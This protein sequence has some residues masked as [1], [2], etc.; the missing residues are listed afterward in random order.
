MSK[1][2]NKQQPMSPE[3]YL[4]EKARQ[5]PIYKCYKGTEHG[6]IG[7]M[8]IVVARQHKQGTI[9]YAGFLLDTWCVGVKNAFWRFSETQEDFEELIDHMRDNLADFEEISYV[10]AHNWIYG[11]KDWATN[12]GIEPCKDFALAKYLLEE[13]DDNVELIEYDFG[14]EG[15][16]VLVAFSQQEANKY[17]PALDRNL[18]KGNYQVLIQV[19]DEDDYEP[20]KGID[21][22]QLRESLNKLSKQKDVPLMEYTYQ[23]AG[24]PNVIQLHHPEILSILYKKT[25]DIS[26][27]EMRKVLSL[28]SDRLREDLHNII[29]YEIG[30]YHDYVQAG[31]KNDTMLHWPLMGNAMMFLVNVGTKEESLPIVLEILRQD[32][33]FSDY[34]FSDIVSTFV[35]PL[36]WLYCKDE[37]TILMPYLLEKGL[38]TWMKAEALGM[39]QNIGIHC[40]EQRKIVCTMARDLFP[41]YK[42]DLPKR[43]LCDGVVAAF[44]VGIAVGIGATELLPQI[45]EIYATGLV[46]ESVEGDINEV[47]K[48]IS[49]PCSIYNIPPVT[50]EA[51]YA[52]LVRMAKSNQ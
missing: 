34:Y 16:Y 7:E 37:P 24:Y 27:A 42:A 45:E 5:L 41:I 51:I 6:S 44:L 35:N 8:M 19:D 18:G 30:L 29:L 38:S 23:G 26:S 17:I 15:E 2:S 11:A 22:A 3:R 12:A 4:R 32:D 52:E 43:E 50:S 25:E 31:G 20:E 48:E 10:E 36:L 9:T 33:D 46:D 47:R 39:L 14:K 49:H 1:K 13:D 21:L 28:P 40:P